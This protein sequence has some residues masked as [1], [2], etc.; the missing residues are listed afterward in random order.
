MPAAPRATFTGRAR[1]DIEQRL[2]LWQPRGG[3]KWLMCTE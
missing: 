2:D 3:L 1:M